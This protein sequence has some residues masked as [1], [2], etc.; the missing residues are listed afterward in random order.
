MY[1]FSLHTTD[2]GMSKNLS[3]F[4]L[5]S[6]VLHRYVNFARNKDETNLLAVQYKGSILYHCCRTIHPG[7][8]LMVWPSS[9]FLDRFSEAWTQVWVMKLNA[10]GT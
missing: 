1:T 9:K 4:I 7:E 10:T 8:E 6:F 3:M 5:I 2:N